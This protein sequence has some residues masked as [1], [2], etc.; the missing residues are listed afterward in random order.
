[1]SAILIPAAILAGLG[2]LFG[3]LLAV[4]SK[5]FAVKT[6]ER[7]SAVRE[8][9]PGANCGGCGYSGC[10]ALAAAIV[11][12]KASPSACTAGGNAVAAKVA[13]IMGVSVEAQK[14]MRAFIHCAG[15]DAVAKRKYNYAGVSD[16]AAAEKLAGGDKMCAAGCLGHLSCAAVCPAEAIRL[17]N[18]VAVVDAAKCIGCGAC[19]RVCPKHLI[20]MV[21]RDAHY[22]VRCSS[23]AKGPVLLNACRAGCIGCGLCTRV[24]ES[25]AVTVT[26]A[27]ASIDHEKCIGCGKCAEKCPR[28][29]IVPLSGVPAEEIKKEA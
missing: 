6:D 24:C 2:A 18:G 15:E 17:E 12:G 11:E 16:C 3:I 22:I 14:P 5:V 20:E 8:S 21:P 19:T 29:I 27:L 7:V 9:L 13:A 10:D 23:H 1:M 26:D 28:H 25:G 4:A